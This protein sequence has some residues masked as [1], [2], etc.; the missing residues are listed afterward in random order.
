MGDHP[1]TSRT[2]NC[3]AKP[4]GTLPRIQMCPDGSYC[5]DEAGAHCCSNKNGTFVDPSGNV[6]SNPY[7]AKAA[8]T[9]TVQPTSTNTTTQPTESPKSSQGLTP[10]AKGIIGALAGVLCLT[11]AAIGLFFWRK[12]RETHDAQSKLEALQRQEMQ[13]NGMQQQ[14]QKGMM[15]YAPAELRGPDASELAARMS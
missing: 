7:T 1:E 12:R 4:D 6:I 15:G 3:E 13:I 5:C 8:A 11:L 9:G 14:D 2:D 10:A